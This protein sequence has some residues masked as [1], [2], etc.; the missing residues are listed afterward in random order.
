MAYELTSL[1][2]LVDSGPHFR[3][4]MMF[5]RQIIFLTNKRFKVKVFIKKE[6]DC[7][8]LMA[9]TFLKLTFYMITESTLFTVIL[10]IYI[11]LSNNGN[12]KVC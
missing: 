4:K 6:N 11:L 9:G 12:K 7:V 10:N 2:G 1:Y 3:V 8:T 5:T